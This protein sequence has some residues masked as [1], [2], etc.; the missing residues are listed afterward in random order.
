M[1]DNDKI[2]LYENSAPQWANQWISVKDRLPDED[3]RYLV[4]EN[5]MYKWVGVCSMRN[6]EFEMSV[7]YWMPLPEP[8]NE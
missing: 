8:P 6:G 2:L 1:S 4:C 5:H 7:S 3:G